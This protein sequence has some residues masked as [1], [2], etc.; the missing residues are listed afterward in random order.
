MLRD[1]FGPLYPPEKQS[2]ENPDSPGFD[3][4]AA[5][6]LARARMMTSVVVALMITPAGMAWAQGS[7]KGRPAEHTPACD[8]TPAKA[9]FAPTGWKTVAL[10][11]FTMHTVDYKKEAGYYAALMNW[12][13]RSDDGQQAVLDIGDDVGTVVIRGGYV[14]PP[15]PPPRV[16]TAADSA[17][18]RAGRGGGRGGARAPANAVWDSFAW[19]ISPW[20][21]K[22][23]ET[24]LKK[25]GLD[26]IA[27]NDGKGFESFHVKDPDGFD[28]QLTNGGYAKIRKARK[29]D[30]VVPEPEPFEHT[31]WKTVWLDHISFGVTNY[32]E[33]V[34]WYQALLGWMPQGDEGSQNETWMCKECGNVIIRGGNPMNTARPMPA[35]RR[36]SIGHISFGIEPFDPDSVKAEL[37]KRG[38]NS[39]MDT[40][41]S[42]DIHDPT[43]LY[44]SYH[45]TTPQGFDLQISNGTRA[46]RTVR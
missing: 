12:T 10:D 41:T 37:D 25:R 16:P 24:E 30:A 20:N 45:T 14:A 36:A 31:K 33:S 38:L 9:P 40:G 11:H 13:V 21:A 6:T 28:V 27:D 18:G 8:T 44:K 22:T 23:V 39:R 35:V 2:M 1:P 15:P 5:L 32:K 43:A 42:K 3:G 34:A 19:Q 4:R 17:A 29:S 46:N 7:C 26:P